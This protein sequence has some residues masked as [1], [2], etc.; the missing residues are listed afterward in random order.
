MNVSLTIMIL[1]HGNHKF[2]SEMFLC[3]FATMVFCLFL[4]LDPFFFRLNRFCSCVNLSSD[5]LRNF[6]GL[7]YCP[8]LRVTKSI[9]PTSIPVLVLILTGLGSSISQEKETYQ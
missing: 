2:R 9:K 5:S 4:F 7:T 8:L 3:T 1:G 6:G